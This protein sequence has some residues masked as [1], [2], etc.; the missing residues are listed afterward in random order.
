MKYYIYCRKSTEDAGK[1]IQSI[2]AQ[3]NCLK[4]MALER[5][6]EVVDVLT[7][8]KSAKTP[9][10]EMFLKMIEGIHQGKASG[11]LCWKMDRLARNPVDGG[12]ISWMLQQGVIQKIIT[13]DREYL[14]TDNVLMMSVELGMANQYIRD[15]GKGVERGMKLKC[16]KGWFP[17]IVPQGY[18]NDKRGIKGARIV[19]KDEDR[20][21]MVRNMWEL[22]LTGQYSLAEICR[23]ANEEW[24][25]RTP[26]TKATGGVKLRKSTLHNMFR[27]PFYKG[28]F[29]W[30]GELFEGK[31][32]K[33][34]T[35]KEYEQVQDILASKGHKRPYKKNFAYTGMMRCGEC[36][37][38]I[39]AAQKRKGN[40]GYI[41]YHCTDQKQ[42]YHCTQ[43]S[44]EEKRLE[45]Q[46]GAFLD[47]LAISDDYIAW[48]LKNLR[49]DH[50]IE[51]ADRKA[52]RE[53]VSKSLRE[54]E[55]KLDRL[56]SMKLSEMIEDE[57]FKRK[58][59]ELMSEKNSLME[60]FKR[61]DERQDCW[62]DMAEK[63]VGFLSSLKSRFNNGDWEIKKNILNVLGSKFVLKD[64]KVEITAK[65]IYKPL[66]EGIKRNGAILPMLE[67]RKT[68]EESTSKGVFRA[69]R[70]LWC[71]LLDEVR[72]ILKDE[73]KFL[74]CHGALLKSL[75]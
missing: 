63:A 65:G 59:N 22:A 51:V 9:G 33:M 11:I 57:L 2:E 70:S 25:Y 31:H 44:I 64:G 40:R 34:I 61:Q 15:L 74:N 36:G 73:E 60:K 4:R 16:E 58:K 75:S 49:K 71:P 14:P 24:G 62:I 37:Y 68:V 42:G 46:I 27:N 50:H 67:P 66:Q 6:L 43:R 45:E 32:E 5:G 47:T 20:F 7:E 30:R 18:K 17:G 26:K 19:R 10:R 29:E 41:Y 35:E 3:E 21:P 54:C 8:C 28:M 13:I 12:N 56:V 69:F 48:L 38:M 1:Q 39:T 72:T 55:K 52:A 23:V 53:S